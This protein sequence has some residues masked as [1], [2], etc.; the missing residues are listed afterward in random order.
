[1]KRWM[2]WGAAAL[3][4]ILCLGFASCQQK[5]DEPVTFEI[6][7]GSLAVEEYGIG[8][9][10]DD[11]LRDIVNS[12]LKVLEADGTLE[13]ISQE[14]FGFDIV[15]IEGDANALDGMDTQA[16]RTFI[17]GLDD[18][19]P[20][21]GYRN[22]ENNIVG[23]D[24]DMAQAV[25]DKLEWELQVQP[26]DWD[27][28]ELELNSGTID[29]IWNGMTLT[30]ERLETMSCSDP[31]MAN[32][33]VIVVRKDSGITSQEDLAGKKL[34]LQAGSSA[35]GALDAAADFKASLGSV[36]TFADNMTCF[37]D[38]EQGSSDAVL[39][40]SIVAGWYMTSGQA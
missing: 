2:R 14:W 6:L 15:T 40:D 4:L 19:F 18:S 21:M 33:Q 34:C 32:E 30:D 25:C 24:I 1:M 31:Y 39:V 28:K 11:E 36:N 23:F 37:M 13:E 22:D 12:A 26:I 35:E 9:R 16:G 8:F 5:T 17:L 27:A 29:C 20:P 10:K 3:C 7:E 38:L